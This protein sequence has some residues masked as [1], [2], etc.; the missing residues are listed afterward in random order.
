[1]PPEPFSVEIQGESFTVSD[2]VGTTGAA[3]TR[4]KV[5]GATE[6]TAFNPAVGDANNDDLWDGFTG[7]GYM[8]MGGNA[9]DS[10]AFS[11]DAPEA[12]V[13]TVT[14]RYANGG[15]AATTSRPMA[16]DVDG[17]SAGNVT[18]AG[19]G[20]GNWYTWAEE[21]VSV[22]LAAGINTLRLANTINAG[23]NIDR[24]V[25]ARD[26]T[27]V[28]EPGA[29]ETIRIDFQDG[30]VPNVA[31]YLVDNFQG[32]GDRGNGQ[33]Y[34]WVTE[35]SAI[36]ADPTTATAIDG[37]LYPA[38]AINERTGGVFATYD[39]RLTDYAHFDLAGQY[40]AGDGARVAW[41]LGVAN[42]WYE[43]TVAVGDTAGPN[44]SVN[45]LQVEGVLAADFVPTDAA[46]TTLSTVQVQV[47]DG[48]LTLTQ[49]GGTQTEIQYLEVRALPDL[50][51]ADANPAPADYASFTDP[52]AVAQEGSEI[53]QVDLDP[54]SGIATGVDP[55]ADLFL[56]IDVVEGRGGVLFD[57]L[58]D[59]SFRLVETL[60]G[61][62]V[63]FAINTTA[64][65][66][67]ITISPVNPLK[68]NTSYTLVVDGAQDRGSNEDDGAPTREFQ[69]FSTTF[70]T[71]AAR[72]AQTGGV[73]FT[74]RL[75]ING[76]ADGAFGFTS[77]EISPDGSRLFVATIS[78]EIKSWAL[79]PVTGAIDK[80][81]LQTLTPGGDFDTA[82]G[83]RGII[84]LTF[85]PT[86][87]GTIWITD[88]YPI[89]LDGRDNTVPEFSGRISKV[90]LGAGGD[91]AT[92]G[93]E[94]YIRGLPRSNGDHVTNSLEFRAN[95]DYDAVTNPDVPSHLLY[96]L[97][98]SNSAMGQADSAWGFRPERLLNAAV[99]EIDPT[100]TPPAGGFDVSTEPVPEDGLNRRY[101]DTD[102]DLKNGGILITDGAFVGK[103]LHFDAQGLASVR[104]GI[105]A[106]TALLA[107]YYN[108]FAQDAVLKL[109]AT[110]QRNPYD[111]VWHSNGSLYVPTNGSAAGGNVPDDPSTVQNEGITNVSLQQDYLFTVEEGGYY[112]HPNPVRGDFILNGGNPTAGVD[113]NQVPDYA[114]GTQADPNYRIADA[115][116]LGNNRS[117]NG[118]IEYTSNVWGTSLKG[119]II[120]TEYSGGNDIR[121]VRLDAQGNPVQDFVLHDFTG[122]V[123]NGYPDPLDIIENPET[124]Q[125]YLITLNRTNG[126]SQIVRLDPTPPP[127]RVEAEALTI[128]SG[129]TVA[130]SST[131]SG[132]QILQAAGSGEQ[133]ANHV[134]TGPAGLYNIGIGHYDENDGTARMRILVNGVAVDGFLWNKQLGSGNAGNATKA[135]HTAPSILLN[136]G[137]V[138][139]I[140][141][142]QNAGEPLRTDYLDFSYVGPAGS[143]GAAPVNTAPAAAS[144][145]AGAVLGFTGAN[146]LS[147]ADADTAELT[148]TL[149]VQNGVLAVGA[150]TVATIFGSG[151]GSVVVSGTRAQVNTVLS[152]LTYS[153]NAGYIGGDQLV[154]RTTDGATTDTDTVA[155]T[156]APFGDPNAD[157]AVRSLD[158]A[159]FTNRL[160][161]NWIDEPATTSATNRDFKESA[162]VQ[163][164]N[165]GTSP[166]VIQGHT[167]EGPFTLANPSQLTNLVIQPG[168]TVNVQVNFNRAAFAD[169]INNVSSVFTGALTLTTNDLEDNTVRI[170]LAGSWQRIDEGSWEPNINEIWE[171]FGFG[172]F[173]PGMP[174]VDSLPGSPLN[175]FGIVEQ[176]NALEITS[177]YWQIAS[178]VTTAKITHIAAYQG[179]GG[180]QLSFHQ[181]FSKGTVPAALTTTSNF[182]TNQMILPIKSNGQQSTFTFTNATIPD[183]WQGT[184]VFGIKIAN[185]S[186]DPTLNA[187]G[188]LPP[189]PEPGTV[190]GYWTRVFQAIDKN[191]AVIPN[192]YLG[193][194]DFTGSNGDYNDNLFV[195]EGVAPASDAPV[196]AAPSSITV[197][198]DTASF[199]LTG[200]N[201]ISVSD[202]DGVDM[203]PTINMFLSVLQGTLAITG[204]GVTITGNGTAALTLSG[205]LANV[206]A[207]LGNLRYTPRPNFDGTDTLRVKTNDRVLTDIDTVTITVTPG[208]DDIPVVTAVSAPAITTAGG[209]TATVSVT[210]FDDTGLVPGS[211][212]VSDIT[213]TGPGGE[214]L[215]VTGV[216]VTPGADG[217]SYVAT[218]TVAARGGSWYPSDNGTYTVAL[219]AGAVVDG[220]SQGIAGNPALANFAVNIPL[221]AATRIQAEAFTVQS[222]FV[223]AN[224]GNASGGQFL[225]AVGAGEQRASTTFTGPAGIHTLTLGYFD[226]N[227]G[228]ASMRILVNGVQVDSWSWNQNLGTPNA[229]AAART[230]RTVTGITLR[231]G[232]VIEIRGFQ[233]GG[234]P[235]R[236]DYLDITFVEPLVAG[237]SAPV[238]TAPAA[239]S[240]AE[241]AVLAFTGARTVSVADTDSASLSVSLTVGQ[242]VLA[243]PAGAGVTITGSGTG[244]VTLSGS[245]AAVNAVLAGL[246][247]TPGANYA[248]GDTLSIVT[249]DGSLSDTDSVAITVTP[250]DD[251]PVNTAPAAATVAGGATLA[252][253]GALGVSVAD[254]DS[255]SLSV[256]LTVGQGVLAAPQE[257]GVTVTG[258]GTAAL[259]LS[260]SPAAVNAALAALTYTPAAGY[261]GGDS[262][263]IVTSDGVLG[264]TDSVAITVTPSDQN[265]PTLTGGSA[266]GVSV[267]G[268]TT[269]TVTLTFA[270]DVAVDADSIDVN[271]ITV[272]G[273]GGAV[274]AVTGVSVSPAGDGTPRSATYTLAARGGTWDGTDNGSYRVDL[275]AAQVLDTAGQAVAAATAA[276]TVTVAIPPAPFRVQA[277]SLS[278]VAGFTLLSNTNASG[279]V[280]IQSNSTTTTA[281]ATYGFT[282]LDGLYDIGVGYYDENDGAAS[283]AIL[284]NGVSVASWVWNQN[285][286]SAQVVTAT[287][288]LFT[289][290]D[291]ELRAGDVVELRGQANAGE[292]LRTDYLD[293]AYQGTLGADETDPVVTGASAPNI[294]TTGAT[295]TT[296]TVTFAD[297]V[298]VDTASIDVTDLAVT[299]PGGVVVAVTGVSLDVAASGTPRIATYTLAAPGGTWNEADNGTYT[300]AL[301]ADAVR[302]GAGNGVAGNAA[303][304]SFSVNT[305][306]V[307]PPAPFR[308]E[309][310]SLT[311]VAGFTLASNV[312]ASGGSMIQSN[313]TTVEARA[314]TTFT[315]QSG[316]YDVT[317]GYFDEN[318]GVA[319]M[320]LVVDGQVVDSWSWNQNLGSGQVQ[321]STRAT[322]LAD[323][324]AIETGDVVELRG[325]SNAG[326]PLRTDYLN[327]V[328]VDDLAF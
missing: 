268:G 170:D 222:G 144:V 258:S 149:S 131:A 21:T 89:P 105:T 265:A 148:T 28:V 310:E 208:N 257:A 195:I 138:V 203:T 274:L 284:V 250:V 63:E 90:T 255:A 281:R 129:F 317:I 230:T 51:P 111:L 225:A 314:T 136:T 57:S 92:A 154:L 219:A 66:D 84:G 191:G 245:P 197:A 150:S 165:T 109:F 172:N 64:G 140:A 198:E 114:V 160:H 97:Q 181:P 83:R 98:G 113:P 233:N 112:G 234:E 3:L 11:V 24:V 41:Q 309:A 88:N 50:T 312:H 292:P 35:A 243:V 256:S 305:I 184:D 183:S 264:D 94:T 38:I 216:S 218:Y 319:T 102:G 166:L 313:T 70:V 176:L 13:Y 263:G 122:E 119:A 1:M 316:L 87:P 155:I 69:K 185:F 123:I 252:F 251:A 6:G 207:A 171:V 55:A 34:G 169:R 232:D 177:P 101:A 44:D 139:S 326:E 322:H 188:T 125:I 10:V 33:S 267:A 174:F 213:V 301:L 99:M 307:P 302:D 211:I 75:E 186:T 276:A 146:A 223:V 287:R 159:F 59:G 25:V 73:A 58:T 30:T 77:V 249:S 82:A 110:G 86:D 163:L 95:P 308:I 206:N 279:G 182:N 290:Q 180:T 220:G 273:P 318:D 261:S 153:G 117:P 295:T 133:V 311:R 253:T 141:G 187:A 271:D 240:V 161:F 237:P 327:F 116:G 288:A 46:K 72:P 315:A 45:R 168:A 266:P 175:N 121:A 4:A 126:Q 202:V 270:D 306:D 62:V 194:Q 289:A 32:Y 106:D 320:S 293:F 242:G 275:N 246:T 103:Y 152:S 79:D 215:G 127:T 192:V 239:A 115:Y 15:G 217:R 54:V 304:A 16:L 179:G 132:G 37:S 40:P 53:F 80:L 81:S 14:V 134:F 214:A 145:T 300:V 248:G 49:V 325:F 291:V 9:G 142:L 178:G 221:P 235:L 296:V 241:D 286:G 104:E 244:A 260:G 231:P 189:N 158:A 60:T 280:L 23:P 52:R 61:A 210:Y 128:Q 277:E 18:F 323:D 27:T 36:D 229:D 212:G 39:Q 294:T 93:I 285:L 20:A 236:T 200:A 147:V 137:D 12:G 167:L 135:L 226:E 298:G 130:A 272:T 2:T 68:P 164:S 238:N 157:I 17:I 56:G 8:D 43:V 85:D 282:A 269:T 205:S 22:T 71:G 262:L 247:Y 201:R 283:M 107:E 224:N 76:A 193:V 228:V 65:A 196:N 74:D 162:I 67:S 29:R 108:P 124:G 278:L 78:G 26:T 209:T 96:V 227:D 151:T 7:T 120:F 199:A 156:I 143:A 328:Y 299:G 254:I 19:T 321:P 100:R 5:P 303:V 91:L 324:I 173:I 259:T 42:G 31:G 118:A 190:F 47:T 204:S 48:F 297:N